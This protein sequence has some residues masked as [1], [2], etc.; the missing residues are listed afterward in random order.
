M[1]IGSIGSKI[2]NP[3]ER[4]ATILGAGYGLYQTYQ[5]GSLREDIARLLGGN[6]HV[7]DIPFFFSQL[8]TD[9]AYPTTVMAIL[10]GYILQES[11]VSFLSRGGAILQKAG[12]GFLM[13]RLAELGLNVVTHSEL[14]PSIFGQPSNGGSSIGNGR[15]YY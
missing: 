10:A 3:I 6:L 11:G 5:S 15:A 4:N 13:A 9:A 8:R 12:V 2:L 14:P 1:D 7:P